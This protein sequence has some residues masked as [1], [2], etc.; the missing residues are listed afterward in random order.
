[1]EKIWSLYRSAMLMSLIIILFRFFTV[2]ELNYSWKLVRLNLKG[3]FHSWNENVVFPMWGK[4]NELLSGGL[5]GSA[6]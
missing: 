5:L 2:K 1:M 3:F 6:I 4:L